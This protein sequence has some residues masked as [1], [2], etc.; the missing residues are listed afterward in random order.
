MA[1][2][3]KDIE[4]AL[5]RLKKEL[6]SP[7]FAAALTAMMNETPPQSRYVHLDGTSCNSE[8]LHVLSAGMKWCDDHDRRAVPR[9]SER[10]RRAV[11]AGA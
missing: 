6:E 10:G 8:V 4:I 11:E 7:E 9:N 3:K 5:A 2:S 1:P